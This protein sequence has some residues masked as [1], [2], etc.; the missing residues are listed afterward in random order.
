MGVLGINGF[1]IGPTI[2]AM[3]IVVWH[4]SAAGVSVI[5]LGTFLPFEEFN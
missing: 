4:L 1:I 2:A 3:F 5:V